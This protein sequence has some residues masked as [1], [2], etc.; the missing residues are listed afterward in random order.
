MS[1]ILTSA[2]G[3]GVGILPGITEHLEPVLDLYS[4]PMALSGLCFSLILGG[5]MDLVFNTSVFE[6]DM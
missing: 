4:K 6:L 3:P 1:G 2:N 5:R